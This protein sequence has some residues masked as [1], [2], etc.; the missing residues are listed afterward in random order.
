LQHLFT[1]FAVNTNL[2][3]NQP[4]HLNQPS[5]PI[6]KHV[7]KIAIQQQ[8]QQQQH[9]FKK[10]PTLPTMSDWQQPTTINTNTK[11]K[12]SN[13]LV[14]MIVVSCILVVA[15]VAVLVYFLAVKEPSSSPGQ[16]GSAVCKAETGVTCTQ[17]GLT[18]DCTAVAVTPTTC[19]TEPGVTCTKT[20]TVCD[21]T[22]DA[23][24]PTTCKAGTGVTCT[25]TGSVCDCTA[26]T[27]TAPTVHGVTCQLNKSNVYECHPDCG[28]L[29]LPANCTAKYNATTQLC[30]LTCKSASQP[31]D[32]TNSQT[33]A[34]TDAAGACRGSVFLG[35]TS[36][37]CQTVPKLTS[38]HKYTNY[39]KVPGMP[40]MSHFLNGGQKALNGTGT[41]DQTDP[42]YNVNAYCKY[43]SSDNFCMGLDVFYDRAG[44][45]TY[46]VP[47]QFNSENQAPNQISETPLSSN[48]FDVPVDHFGAVVLNTGNSLHTAKTVKKVP[49]W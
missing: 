6:Y 47:C 24:A 43:N 17:S 15:L 40:Q 28:Q 35:T 25:K 11:T 14:W 20:G 42:W 37:Y 5:K 39:A 44:Q 27:P 3:S 4:N 21:C 23:V 18:C 8:Q 29:V 32:V 45:Q 12:M 30:E 10:L 26:D 41:T 49:G 19:K 33:W 9:V 7:A 34:A 48:P 46:Y 1:K 38:N 31:F 22:A 2:P 13:Q 16:P 36:E